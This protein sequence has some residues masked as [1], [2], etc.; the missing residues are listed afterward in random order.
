MLQ[1]IPSKVVCDQQLNVAGVVAALKVE[2]E[3]R[4]VAWS[5]IEYMADFVR[6][7]ATLCSPYDYDD[8]M[9][10]E[11]ENKHFRFAFYRQLAYAFGYHGKG[12]RCKFDEQLLEAVRKLWP[13][14]A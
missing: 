8:P 9:P 14:T 11:P 7:P 12:N 4:G 13:D 6:N 3:A 1:G 10:K 2:A 5:S